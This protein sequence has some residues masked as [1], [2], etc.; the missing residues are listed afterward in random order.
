M[1]K[2]ILD[3]LNKSA[4]LGRQ[5]EQMF[6]QEL[7]DLYKIIEHIAKEDENGNPEGIGE[8][9][10]RHGALWLKK[11]GMGGAKELFYYD[12]SEEKWIPVFDNILNI[13]RNITAPITMTNHVEG[14]LRLCNDHLMYYTQGEWRPV[15]AK[16]AL[17]N[18]PQLAFFKDF[19]IISPLSRATDLTEQRDF[20]TPQADTNKIFIDGLLT[21]RYRAQNDISIRMDKEINTSEIEISSVHVNPSRLRNV[22]TR[23][24]KIER[25]G[26]KRLEQIRIN[27]TLSEFY[28]IK[29]ED[30]I[31]GNIY[32]G[33]LLIPEN[34]V[35]DPE[36]EKTQVRHDY[37]NASNNENDGIILEEHV[38]EQYEYIF[39]VEYEFGWY[40]RN[41]YSCK[42]FRLL[43]DSDYRKIINYRKPSG[44]FAQ[45]LHMEKD[46]YDYDEIDNVIELPGS[47]GLS[48]RLLTTP[49]G[50]YGETGI[51]QKCDSNNIG[52]VIP[53]YKYNKPLLFVNGLALKESDET[54]GEYEIINNELQIYQARTG[55]VYTII[56]T[57]IS[58]DG[59][60]HAEQIRT[61]I[62]QENNSLEVDFIDEGIVVFL[63]G[64][65]I[66]EDLDVYTI[67][68]N[69]VTFEGVTEKQT[70]MIFSKEK[71]PKEEGQFIDDI[72]F[73]VKKMD[74]TQLFIG[75]KGKK[76]LLISK[77]NIQSI[78]ISHHDAPIKNEILFD[79]K[80]DTFKIYE[81]DSPE[82]GKWQEYENVFLKESIL[83]YD[84]GT[85]HIFVDKRLKGK[86]IGAFMYNFATTI[87]NRVIINSIFKPETSEEKTIILPFGHKY[88]NNKNS[89]TLFINGI[90]QMHSEDFEIEEDNK[91]ISGKIKLPEIGEEPH[92]I[93]Y[94]I[95]PLNRN[96][97]EACKRIFLEERPGAP[98]GYFYSKDGQ[99][100]YPGF[101]NIYIDGIRQSHEKFSLIDN[102]TIALV[103]SSYLGY[104]VQEV[105]AE[106]RDDPMYREYVFNKEIKE[107]PIKNHYYI[108]FEEDE[109]PKEIF[110]SQ[111][112]VKIFIDGLFVGDQYWVNNESKQIIF[113]NFE[114]VKGL[115]GY[116]L[117]DL[118]EKEKYTNHAEIIIEWR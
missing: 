55:M 59:E 30:I 97:N 2:D 26:E 11:N 43:T 109:L 36:T 62:D 28:G 101:L 18:N 46:S 9:T 56:E 38:S 65:L 37:F 99:E 10:P 13:T 112:R 106:L 31:D 60:N 52:Y 66:S 49:E 108:S 14:E 33:T 24:F 91:D 57:D 84:S 25:P 86:N 1:G 111:D 61:L 27:P 48:V 4:R 42:E 39:S 19:D 68:G 63:D 104:E 6:N 69:T 53:Y 50:F 71:F 88:S 70:C 100:I 74:Y 89:M 73:P 78:E 110:D 117:K 79:L 7:H 77:E 12:S 116:Y 102:K 90:R 40:R 58:D 82:E 67:D 75:E 81:P 113:K 115:S 87:E 20:I 35:C 94:M 8:E 16:E 22:K 76:K 103:E 23:L 114:T 118:P 17:E 105:L 29:K 95:E 92:T 5:S 96:M 85:S 93:T 54:L 21:G 72:V 44:L 83:L 15:R 64:F 98:K 47:N 107:G 32:A 3:Q 45:S 80:E 41:G 34:K 51:V